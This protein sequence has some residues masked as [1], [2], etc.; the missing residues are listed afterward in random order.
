MYE[1]AITGIGIISSIGNGIDQV[2]ESLKNGRSGIVSNKERCKLG[3]RSNL[4][5]CIKNFTIPKLDRKSRK[6]MT[7]FTLQAYV[8]SLEA[9]QIAGWDDN[10]IRSPKTGIIF[11]NDSSA[12][13]TIQSHQIVCDKKST[14]NIGANRVFMSLNSTISMNLNTLFGNHGISITISAACASG[15]HAIGIASDMIAGGRQ[16]RII[17]GGAQE[18]TWESICSFDATNAFSIRMDSPEEASR[19]FDKD[20]DGLIPSGGAAV[21]A[22]E[23]M[24]L[25]KKRGANI[26]GKIASYEFSSDG[27]KLSLPSGKGLKKCMLGCILRSG[28]KLKDIDYISAHATSTPKGDALEAKAI[29][30]VFGD[31]TP[32][33]SSSKSM[34]GHEMWMSGASQIVYSTIMNMDNFIAPNINFKKQEPESPKL[35]IVNKTIDK[36]PKVVLSNSAGFGGTNSCLIVD[37]RI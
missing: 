20:R 4:T 6:T 18:I 27:D 13:S 25:A 29:Y 34:T 11:G 28:I 35:N 32:W 16:D 5:G 31:D 2:S 23:R 33:I 9:I 37:Y 7:D 30:D 1:V 10:D 15:G 8:S 17:C 36:K 19:P 14:L 3:F 24:D 12:V 26:L 21:I 22:L